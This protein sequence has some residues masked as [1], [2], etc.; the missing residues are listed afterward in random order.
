MGT[1][2]RQTGYFSILRWRS[3]VTR[4]EA[5]N[6]GVILV[7]VHGRFG[8]VKAAPLSTISSRL[9]EQGLLDQMIYGLERQFA[10]ETKPALADLKHLYERL[11]RSIYLTEPQQIA[12]P[13]VDTALNAIY[14]AYV[15]PRQG[16]A[17]G[18]TKGALMDRVVEL[19]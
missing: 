8:G 17:R 15:A 14:R 6:V 16:G 4:D 11:E 1:D 12:V 18:L 7:D 3:D 9:R 13:D 10:A 19:L 2:I 5:K